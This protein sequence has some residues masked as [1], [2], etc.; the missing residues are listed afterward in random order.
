MKSLSI[1]KECIYDKIKT[2]LK[3]SFIEEK[4]AER[5]GYE[6]NQEILKNIVE[7]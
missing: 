2:D 6:I 3:N 5:E 7:M 4:E 1:F